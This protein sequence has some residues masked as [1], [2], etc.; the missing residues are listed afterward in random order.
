MYTNSITVDAVIDALGNFLEPFVGDSEIIRGQ[1]NRV[2]PP[3]GEFVELT[4]ITSVDLS[5]PAVTYRPDDNEADITGPARI[6]IQVDFYGPNAGDY[7]KSAKAAFRTSW[8]FEQFPAGIKPLYMSDGIQ[9]PLITGEKQYE[10]RWTSTAS[11][12]YNPI[13]TVPQEFADEAIPN[14]VIPADL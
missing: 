5:V 10:S 4:D 3:A 11:L 1:V 6:E 9:A 13:I 14:I 12:Q 7:C 8:G 2:S